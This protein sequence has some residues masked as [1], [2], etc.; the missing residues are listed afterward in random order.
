MKGGRRERR[1]GGRREEGGEGLGGK[2]ERRENNMELQEVIT[3]D[4]ID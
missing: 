1:I 4:Y 3:A 2:G